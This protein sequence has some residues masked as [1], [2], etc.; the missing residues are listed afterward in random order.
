MQEQINSARI[1]K[2]SIFLVIRMA[3]VMV[4][5]IFTTRYLLA[6]LGVEDYGVYNVTLGI[7]AM[8]S[9]L[10]PA[11][12][13]ANQRYHNYELGKNG[14]EGACKVFN[15]GIRIQGMMVLVIVL[16]AETVGLWYVNEKLVVPDGRESAVFWVYQISILA[17]SLSMLQVPMVSAILAHERMNFYA[18]LNVVDAVLKL[19][20]AI[21]IAY[22]SYDRLVTYSVLLLFITALD[23]I[24][25]S[26][27][28][29]YCFN[30]VR[31][32]RNTDLSL[33][34]GMLAFS[35]WNLFETIARM[36]K[37][38]GCNLLLNF[39]CGPV[40]NAARGVTNQVT[41]AFSSVV[42]STIMA[43][44]PQ[45]V[46]SYAQGNHQTSL[47]MFY[48]LSKGTLLIVFAMAFPVYLE[49][50]YILKLWLGGFIP[51]YTVEL[52]RISIFIILIDKLASPTTALVHATG[53]IKKYHLISGFINIMVIPAAWLML[54]LGFSPTSVYFVT[55]AS[56]LIAQTVFLF[57]IRE[58]L[59]FSLR[60]Y[61]LKVLLPFV[62][63]ALSTMLIPIIL[64]KVLNEGWIRLTV[65]IIT[66]EIVFLIFT[67]L[68]GL[69]EREKEIVLGLLKRNR[70][71]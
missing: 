41:Y 37:E 55:L 47:S 64:S 38:Q 14:I 45:M 59:P 12:S 57:V 63:V 70:K 3:V 5:S 19:L 68:L 29:H 30:E 21:G 11:L 20:I 7:V 69:T 32:K 51:E 42:D 33:L 9:F 24:V 56:V 60:E 16:I 52:V 54:H 65:V 28:S 46:S 36:G 48:T 15:A 27:Y 31:L 13:N 35:G 8:C 39:F 71:E 53:R 18:I 34:K 40:L 6:N 49:V 44:R 26:I 67:I 61:L 2:N 62:T 4:I 22:S 66:T 1:A 43:S 50:E 10:S 17:F 25:Y 58:L 23:F